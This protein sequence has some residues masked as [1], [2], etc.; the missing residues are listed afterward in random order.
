MSAPV[1]RIE[2]PDF[3]HVRTWVFDLDNTLYPSS[4]DLFGQIDA[5]MSAYMQNLLKLPPDEARRLQK[6]YY[7]EHGTTL[8]GLMKVHHID[9]ED[10]LAFVHDIDLSVLTPDPA[11]CA[12]LLRLPGRKFVFTNGCVNHADRVLHKLDLTGQFEEIWDIRT[13]G[14]QP[15]PDAAAYRTVLARAGSD[16][17]Q[18]A[19]FED[20]ARNLVEAKALGMTTVWLKNGSDWSKQGPT[21]PVAQPHH[22]DYETDDLAAFLQ[23]IRVAAP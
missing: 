19:M 3:R 11:L 4:C 1:A 14:F 22:I 17:R 20:I 8:N 23:S 7:H 13:I 10:Y 2:T 6:A 9:A 16:G 18:A 12:A 15:K 5:K 21:L